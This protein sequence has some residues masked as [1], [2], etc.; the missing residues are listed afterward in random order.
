MTRRAQSGLTIM[1]VMIA[2]AVLA[3]MM[4]MAWGT[5]SSTA[6]TKTTVMAYEQRNHEIRMALRRV[7]TDFESAYLSKNEDPNLASTHP[8][9]MFVGKSGS[10]IPEIRFSTLGHRPLWAD[11]N[12]SEQTVIS[13]LEHQNRESGKTDWVR[14]EQRRLSNENP[15]QEPAEFDVLL[16]DVEKVELEYWNWK[17]QEWQD[18]WDTMQSDGQRGLLPSR[19][20]I[21]I[22]VKDL[23]GEAVKHSTQ[24]RVLM[25]EPLNFTN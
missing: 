23:K 5:I 1:E 20:K 8:R 24:A 2:C 17:N 12:E 15:E 13:Y 3:F 18:T 7:V 10:D 16:T 25:Q 9:T 4:A 22:T 21:T 6:R 11:A 14:R 19:V